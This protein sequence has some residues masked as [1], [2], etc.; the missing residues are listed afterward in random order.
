MMAICNV[1]PTP[2][3]VAFAQTP[4][5]P[6][7]AW[8]ES[9]LPTQSPEIESDD[10][11][12]QFS[13]VLVPATIQ[14]FFVTDLYAK[15]SGYV[16]QINSDI[17]D[18]VRKGQALA[19][20]ANPEL[21]AQFDKAQAAVQQ[22]A[23]AVEV[24]KRQITGMQADLALQEVTL[25]RQK[26]LFAGKAA[27]AQMLDEAQA[28]HGVSAANVEIGK[29]K[30]AAAEADVRTAKAEAERVQ[31]LLQYCR[32]VAPFD[33]VV[34]RR[35]VNPGD[36]VQEAIST[37]TTPL[38][39]VQQIDTVR[40][41]A[42]VPESSAAGI[43]PG[44]ASEVTLYGAAETTVHG[45]VTRIAAALDPAT[46]T[47]RVEIDLP[48]LDGTL[49]PGMYAKVTLKLAPQPTA[50]RPAETATPH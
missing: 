38:F 36:L 26:E 13:T 35:L 27:T 1:A 20:I 25:R 19:V 11:I 15:V 40:V 28:K 34:T 12:G 10:N 37:R 41:F 46:R 3:S 8:L 16:S 50:G 49:R 5:A 42:D 43:R 39:T 21:Q 30:L 24:A 45:S 47:M 17:G 2:I 33:G 31:A 6:H 9:A 22:A 18:R 32:I 48:N 23:A 14:A 29:A 44:L 7:P 4:S